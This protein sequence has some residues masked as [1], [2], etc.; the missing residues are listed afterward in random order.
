MKKDYQFNISDYDNRGVDWPE[1]EKLTRE[2]CQCGD[3]GCDKRFTEE[4]PMELA[5]KCH[6]GAPLVVSYWDGWL[7]FRCSVCDEPVVKIEV[8]KRLI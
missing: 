6:R 2:G 7:Y 8:S 4:N 3:S 1:L 5:V